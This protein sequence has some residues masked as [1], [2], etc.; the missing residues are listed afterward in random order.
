MSPLKCD[1][2]IKRP[3]PLCGEPSTFASIQVSLSVSL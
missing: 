2:R 1:P 3:C